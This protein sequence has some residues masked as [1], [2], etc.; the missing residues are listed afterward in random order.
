VN[1]GTRIIGYV[2]V[3]TGAQGDSGLGLEAQRTA[4]TDEARR[5]G[6]EL[7]EIVE[8]VASGA[9]MRR[10]PKLA[11]ALRRIEDGEAEA[12]IAAKLDRVSRSV[13]DFASL[14][15]RAHK[16]GWKLVVLDL[17]IDTTTPAGEMLA[18][19]MASVAQWE[20]RMIGQ[21]T[22]EAL[23]VKRANGTRLGRPPVVPSD[24]VEWI[25][26]HRQR[27]L[28]YRR[29]AEVLNEHEVPTGHGGREWRPGAVHAI[30]KREGVTK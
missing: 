28:T 23:A 24:V 16:R 17:G 7:V 1:A 13:A 25:V 27:G 18:S 20:R 9:S 3:S 14:L 2:R 15:E 21:R 6:W 22:K 19:I 11:R 4:I 30:C 26:R 10:R 5:R 12:L 29:I 8:D